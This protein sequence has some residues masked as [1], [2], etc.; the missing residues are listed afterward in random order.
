MFCN[1]CGSKLVNEDCSNCY[2]NSA[3]LKKFEEEDD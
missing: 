3:A 1:L 2:T